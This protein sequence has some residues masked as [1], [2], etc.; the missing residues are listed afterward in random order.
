[1]IAFNCPECDEPIEIST[2]R[3]GNR[4][5]CPACDRRI[6]VPAQRDGE[7]EEAPIRFSC[8]KC[9]RPLTVPSGGADDEEQEKRPKKK[10]KKTVKKQKA[11]SG[12]RPVMGSCFVTLGLLKT[13]GG[14]ISGGV[15]FMILG[16]VIGLGLVA[17]GIPYFMAKD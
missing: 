6:R 5:E 17:A 13:I 11:D 8:R 15:L 7:E 4:I 16:P 9:D 14:L 1:M 3:A 2:S 10:V 12:R